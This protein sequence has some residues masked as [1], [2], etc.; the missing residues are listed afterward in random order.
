MA[1]DKS[2]SKKKSKSKRSKS[3]KVE[4]PFKKTKKIQKLVSSQYREQMI[5][6]MAYFKA[7]KRHF[8][9]NCCFRDWLEAE[10]E[11]DV[12]LMK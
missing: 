9:C 4:K 1:K 5:A 12:S 10:K 6:E 8:K 3:D 11:I 7:L 2:K